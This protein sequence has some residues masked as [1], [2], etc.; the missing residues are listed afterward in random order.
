MW[1]HVMCC[2]CTPRVGGTRSRILFRPKKFRCHSLECNTRF[3]VHAEDHGVVKSSF[4]V[5]YFVAD[6]KVMYFGRAD[7]AT[8]Y[9][10]SLGYKVRSPLCAFMSV[11]AAKDTYKKPCVL[12]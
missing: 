8:T 6:G 7:K 10:E 4:S 1:L 2:Y 11:S 5:L 12:Y 9:F 3:Y